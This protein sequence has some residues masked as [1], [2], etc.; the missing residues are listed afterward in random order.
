MTNKKKQVS[1][2][3][4]TKKNVIPIKSTPSYLKQELDKDVI[5][6]YAKQL[7]KQKLSVALKLLKK[8]KLVKD[9]SDKI[10]ADA[11]LKSDAEQKQI[12]NQL[13]QR[14]LIQKYRDFQPKLTRDDLIKYIQERERFLLPL[15]VEIPKVSKADAVKTFEARD[16]KERKARQVA[17]LKHQALVKKSYIR[18]EVEQKKASGVAGETTRLKDELSTTKTAIA[19]K[20]GAEKRTQALIDHRTKLTNARLAL[21]DIMTSIN[22]AGANYDAL[23]AEKQ[24]VIDLSGRKLLKSE[25]ITNFK[26]DH[27]TAGRSAQ[28]KIDLKALETERRQ[29]TADITALRGVAEIKREIKAL[30]PIKP[31]QK[32]QTEAE[33]VVEKLE[34]NPLNVDG[35]IAPY[36][37]T[38]L[39][40]DLIAKEVLERELNDVSNLDVNDLDEELARE[41]QAVD[42]ELERSIRPDEE[43]REEEEEEEEV[44]PPK[45]KE[46]DE[47]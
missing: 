30:P 46:N 47:S 40:Q 22:Q 45:K 10:D 14:E 42:D 25:E 34:R 21:N 11:K 17:E 32:A 1:K 5:N 3:K 27:P 28:Q 6:K 23:I 13:V 35:D 43:E 9:S 19:T 2:V 39:E 12:E 37:R 36:D 26:A 4:K 31:L 24:Q 29:M 18:K 33:A 20:E 16:K 8:A 41:H 44:E 7:E 15:N 38:D